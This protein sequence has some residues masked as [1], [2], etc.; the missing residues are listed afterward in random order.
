TETYTAND[1]CGGD[2]QVVG[3][4]IVGG[5]SG[6]SSVTVLW[7]QVDPA[8]GFGYVSYRSY[9]NCPH[10]TTVKIPVIIETG[11][12]KGPDIICQGKQAKYS[13][14]Q[15]PTTE[16]NWSINGDPNHPMLVFTDQ[17]NE[18][19]V[20]AMDPGGYIIEVYYRNTLLGYDT[21]QGTAK[22]YFHVE[23]NVSIITSKPLT[24]CEGTTKTFSSSNANT[25]VWEI[26]LENNLVY[27]DMA[28]TTSY[29]F[30]DGAGSYVVT[31]NHNGCISDPVVIEVIPTPVISADGISGPDK[32]CLNVPYIY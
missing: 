15:W 6:S 17:R 8:D 26:R 2:W 21:C 10:W 18:I 5:G 29:S 22:F 31:A 28:P 20:D 23:E 11:I 13:L 25:V 12:I 16:F 30:T 4:S 3:G 32:V 1:G 24:V 9:C 14:P 19:M 27:T 7:D